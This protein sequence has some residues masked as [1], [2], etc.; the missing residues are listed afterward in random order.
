MLIIP[1]MY[2]QWFLLVPT[3]YLC[4]YPWYYYTYPTM[5]PLVIIVVHD[6]KVVVSLLLL[7]FHVSYESLCISY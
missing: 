3:I 7:F 6:Y 5:F 1:V 2:S 4:Q